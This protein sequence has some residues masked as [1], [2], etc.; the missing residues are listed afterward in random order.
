MSMNVFS[1]IDV[2]VISATCIFI[3]FIV[4]CRFMIWLESMEKRETDGADTSCDYPGCSNAGV[5]WVC[6]E[7]VQPRR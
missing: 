5:I 3:G 4:G 6:P 2:L 7:H 1:T